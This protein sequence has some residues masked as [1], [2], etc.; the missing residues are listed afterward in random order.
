MG[1]RWGALLGGKISLVHLLSE[2]RDKSE[3]PRPCNGPRRAVAKSPFSTRK[4]GRTEGK[5]LPGLGSR[6]RWVLQAQTVRPCSWGLLAR[7]YGH[8]QKTRL[9]SG[10]QTESEP[11]SGSEG[12]LGEV[13]I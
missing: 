3:F 12:T 6:V 5:G 9:T 10:S 7:F 4:Q 8:H 2:D 1:P 13:L 11:A